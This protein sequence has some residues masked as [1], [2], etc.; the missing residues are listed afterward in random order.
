M[1]IET[2]KTILYHKNAI[3][4]I[5]YENKVRFFLLFFKFW[6]IIDY[7]LYVVKIFM[8]KIFKQL[9]Q[10]VCRYKKRLIYGGLALLLSQI[11]FF[12]LWWIGT[13]NIVFAAEE[14]WNPTSQATSSEQQAS[15]WYDKMSFIQKTV[16]VILYP[17]LAVAW[18]LADNSFVY[19]EI[20]WFDAILWQLWNMVRNL[21]NFALWFIF[22]F[23]IFKYLLIEDKKKDPKWIIIRSLIAGVWIQASWFIMAALV[24]IST[25][26][27]YGVWG[28]PV[29]ILKENVKWTEEESLKY[30]PYYLKNII[31]VDV[32]DL[33]T[34]YMYLTN[35]QTWNVKEWNFYISECETFSFKS[36]K[37]TEELILGPKVIYYIDKRWTQEVITGTDTNRC[38]FQGQVY[39]F[40][41]TLIT[42][43]GMNECKDDNSCHDI[44]IKYK[45]QLD[46]IKKALEWTGSDVMVNYIKNAQILQV[47]DAHTTWWVLWMLWPVIYS[48]GQHYGL[49]LYN[50]WTWEGWQ[51]SRLQDI[52]E[53]KSYVWIFTA[54]Y[55]SLLN[56]WRW[57]IPSWWWIFTSLLRVALSV[58]HVFAIGIPLIAVAILFMMRI[59]ILRMAIALSPMIILLKAFKMDESDF[60]KNWV[61]KYLKVENLLPI[62]FAPA[63][64]CF[65]I[66][67]STVLVIII[68]GL[69]LES[70]ETAKQEILWWLIKMDVWWLTISLWKLIVSVLWIAATRFLVRAAI[71]MSKLW[72]S[73]IIKSLKNLAASSLW[74]IPIVPIPWKGKEWVEFIWANAAFGLNG[75]RW[76]LSTL[77]DKVKAEF[78]WR[79]QTALNEWLDPEWAAQKA[80]EGTKKQIDVGKYW[81][82]LISLDT[83]AL[84][85]KWTE[86]EIE[87][88]EWDNKQKVKFND[89]NPSQQEE[90]I[91]QINAI[92]DNNKKAAFAKV[93]EIKIWTWNDEK[94]YK[95]DQNDNQYKLQSSNPPAA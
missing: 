79:D 16:Y 27:A 75:Q 22:I 25:I 5:K 13:E 73:G 21:A 53:W 88:W 86:T 32:K 56:S 93:S 43:E 8:K 38:H 65:A 59:W 90:V 23:Y 36:D 44:Q 3:R 58:C 50:K 68:S 12:N 55:S 61:F 49:D 72:E 39:Y 35:T 19:W 17:L 34:I 78:E 64:I 52:M 85:N 6:T 18:K 95:F 94:I 74:S 66:S 28:L 92:Q 1:Q 10:W 69:N 51:T 57:V 9:W 87:I 15:K 80:S 45:W 91:K 63:I 76:M 83:S 4:Q 70:I 81:E 37:Y 47:W 48:S 71:G 89:L 2:I 42:R 41:N 7:I 82:K 11:C 40:S 20:F 46:T 54:L 29:T 77:T 84:G 14:P 60:I 24:D 31:Y 33:D 62:I 67:I 30:N 26:L